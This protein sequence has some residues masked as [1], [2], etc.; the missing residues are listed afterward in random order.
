MTL[1]RAGDF[2]SVFSYG[3]ALAKRTP[4][5]V[6]TLTRPSRVVIDIDTPF[7]TVLKKVYFENL[8]RFS[9]GT[10]PYVTA[11]LRP[12]LP[13]APATGVMDRLFAGP[14]EAEYAS[15]LRLQQS[16][17]TGFTGLSITDLVARVRLT[18]GC[19]SGGSTFSIADEIDPTLNQFATVDFVKVY[20]PAG[21]TERHSGRNDS[22]P[23]CLEP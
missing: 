3:I 19:S 4:F 21:H 16:R 12:V 23:V 18:G 22:I 14:T 17:A 9:T 13:G 20:D 6:S 10:Q 2:E 5:H 7:R 11:V 8:P 1:V 15:G